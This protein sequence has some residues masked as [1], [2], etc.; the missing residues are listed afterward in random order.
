MDERRDPAER[1]DDRSIKSCAR[2]GLGVEFSSGEE[3]LEPEVVGRGMIL[4]EAERHALQPLAVERAH[5]SPERRR[6]DDRPEAPDIGG[7]VRAHGMQLTILQ[8]NTPE[9]AAFT[10]AL[11]P[12][13]KA[14][15]SRLPASL[16]QHVADGH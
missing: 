16:L 15:K 11:E 8:P 14:Q 12:L 6:L 10:K 7:D 5:G 2:G 3:L 13:V 9:Y 1:V 4:R